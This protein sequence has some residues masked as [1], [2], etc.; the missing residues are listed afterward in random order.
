MH[1][2]GAWVSTRRSPRAPRLPFAAATSRSGRTPESRAV[3]VGG[4]AIHEFSALSAKRS[5][6]WLDAL[7]LSEHDRAIARLILR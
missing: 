4:L 1:T 7:E 3:K 2:Y 6:E 5:L